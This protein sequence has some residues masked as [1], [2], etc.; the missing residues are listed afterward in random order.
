MD[1]F[2]KSSQSQVPNTPKEDPNV[3]RHGL[4]QAAFVRKYALNALFHP[5]AGMARAYQQ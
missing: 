5:T 3:D 4:K 1:T 2:P